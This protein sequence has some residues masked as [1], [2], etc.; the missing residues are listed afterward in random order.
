MTRLSK[1]LTLIVC[2]A[3]MML[4]GCADSTA[5]DRRVAARLT[6]ASLGNTT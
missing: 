1:H 2:T 6:L 4:V 3:A 5:P